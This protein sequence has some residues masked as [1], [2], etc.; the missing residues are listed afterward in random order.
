MSIGYVT[1]HLEHGTPVL[2]DEQMTKDQFVD[3]T[4]VLYDRDDE[5]YVPAVAVQTVNYSIVVIPVENIAHIDHAPHYT[6]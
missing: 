3:W 2:L 5:K 1:I 6:V 4:T